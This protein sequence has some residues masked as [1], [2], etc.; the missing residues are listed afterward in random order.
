MVD[1]FTKTIH[2]SLSDVYY[3][4]NYFE[5]VV[6]CSNVVITSLAFGVNEPS[7]NETRHS[8]HGRLWFASR[9]RRCQPCFLGA[10]A[11]DRHAVFVQR[12]ECVLNAPS[13]SQEPRDGE[14]ATT[15][16]IQCRDGLSARHRIIVVASHGSPR[17]WCLG[18]GRA[19]AVCYAC[20]A[21]VRVRTPLTDHESGFLFG[22]RCLSQLH[23]FWGAVWRH[24][25]ARYV[26]YS[27][28]TRVIRIT[29]QLLR[30]GSKAGITVTS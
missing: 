12:R 6:K 1:C 19:V 9:G 10:W 18:Q 25:G 23:S 15:T 4:S 17:K 11:T 20:R 5:T 30:L 3:L 16:L 13:Q 26:P 14:H 21:L 24:G 8:L 29:P 2:H 27:C 22:S 28:L 7:T